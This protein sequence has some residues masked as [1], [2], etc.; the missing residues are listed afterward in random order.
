MRVYTWNAATNTLLPVVC[1]W[2]AVII[3]QLTLLL[4]SSLYAQTGCPIP[5][6]RKYATGYKTAVLLGS[7]D[8]PAQAA[9][10]KPT[11]FAT[12]NAPIP[13][14][15]LTYASTYLNFPSQV[16][17]GTPVSIKATYSKSL[18]GVGTAVTVQPFVYDRF[19]AEKLVGAAYA[20]GDLLSLL[21]GTGDMELNFIPKDASGNPVA[22]NGVYIKLS[23]VLGLA[24]SIDIYDAWIMTAAPGNVDCTRP[25]DVLAGTRAGGVSLLSATSWVDNKWNAI[26]NDPSLLTYA[27]L[28]T[29]VQVLSQVF[30]TVVLNTPASAGDSVYIV[31][32]DAGGGLLDLGLL[33]GF[34]IQPYLGSIPAGP[35]ITS[36]GTLLNL[37][38]LAG[39]GTKQILT[40]AIPAAFDRIDIQL[41]GLVNALSSLRIY[42][43]KIV[44]PIPTYSLAINGDF[45][46]GPVCIK[47]ADK[48]KF[49]ITN[50]DPCAAYYWYKA[51]NTLLTTGLSY[52]PVITAAGNYTWYVE[53]VRNGCNGAVKN[54][55]PVT[56]VVDPG[57]GKPVVTIQLNP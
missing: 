56:V 42:D 13:L 9:D 55:V 8:N 40:A 19:G 24:L 26:D 15:G 31:L 41:G 32:Q 46:A 50:P 11:T 14:L 3:C 2:T 6:I 18:L 4:S 49:K 51:D 16:A 44:S 7:V 25:V 43:V 23:G 29:G 53:G 27:Q 17:A 47:E 35:P 30:E 37:R 38:L 57:P 54:R 12:L 21:S 48:L 45:H 22:Y 33:T 39:A 28:N 34:V 10:G 20:I 1:R 5:A 36:N 52:T